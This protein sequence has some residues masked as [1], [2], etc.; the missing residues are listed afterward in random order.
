M[1]VLSMGTSE[2]E[3]FQAAARAVHLDDT[4]AHYVNATKNRA[5]YA[6]VYLFNA[7][8]GD[9]ITVKVYIGPTNDI[10]VSAEVPQLTVQATLA[11]TAALFIVGPIP[12]LIAG[13]PY[14]FV[15][16]H[17]DTDTEIGVVSFVYSLDV[18]DG[19]L[20]V[21]GTPNTSEEKTN[22]GKWNDTAVTL[23]GTTSKPQVSVSDVGGATPTTRAENQADIRKYSKG[24]Y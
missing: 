11:K 6:R 1:R 7:T 5:I 4:T 22:V 20:A 9:V 3:D 19:V 13:T 21:A 16:L 14:L 15:T 10:G 2:T 18:S 8:V 12:M 24:R 23:N 17:D